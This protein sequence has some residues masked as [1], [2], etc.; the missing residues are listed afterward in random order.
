[1]V[2]KNYNAE[3]ELTEFNI[4]FYDMPRLFGV[5]RESLVAQIEHAQR[6]NK[7]WYVLLTKNEMDMYAKG[8][9]R[10]E[11]FSEVGTEGDLRLPVK[12]ELREA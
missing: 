3:I 12:T 4:D 2:S 5:K 1:M 10:E 8:E 7:T 6:K 9:H 11:K